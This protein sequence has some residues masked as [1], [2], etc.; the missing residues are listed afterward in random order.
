MC[1]IWLDNSTKWSFVSLFNHVSGGFPLTNRSFI[2]T[3]FL[4]EN[5]FLKWKCEN[6]H[7]DLLIFVFGVTGCVSISA[8][9]ALVGIP[10]CIAS[11]AVG[12]KSF[13]ISQ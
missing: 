3:R 6:F 10:I 2:W 11:S 9:A 8:F 4:L 7:E 12:L 5:L 1:E 13:A